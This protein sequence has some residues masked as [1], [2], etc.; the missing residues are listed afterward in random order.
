M[1]APLI[2]VTPMYSLCFFGYGLGQ[3]LQ[4]KTPD[5][6]LTLFQIGLAGGFSGIFTTAIIVPG[7]R[8]KC[9]L[10]VRFYNYCD[11]KKE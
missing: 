10:Q 4:R 1:A 8:I 6:K 9:L 2:G 3:Q 11:F 7:E 5:E